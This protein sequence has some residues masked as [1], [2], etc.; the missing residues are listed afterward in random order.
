M[1][2]HRNKWTISSIKKANSVG[3]LD[4]LFNIYSF[5][6]APPP[7]ILTKEVWDH[8]RDSYIKKDKASLIKHLL[9]L[10]RFPIDNPYIGFLRMNK[11]A[12]KNNSTIVDKIASLIKN[13]GINE[14]KHR[15]EASKASSRQMGQKFR[16]WLK[17]GS[18][19]INVIQADSNSFDSNKDF[20]QFDG[21]A[22][23]V[24]SDKKLKEIA[25]ECLGYVGKKGID[26][27]AKINNHFII[28]EAKFITNY[29]GSQNEQFN[30]A[31]S[32]LIM[33][34]EETKPK[35]NI[36]KVA[37]LDGVIYLKNEKFDKYFKEH[38]EQKIMSCL[39]LKDFLESLRKKS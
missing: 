38:G 8:I 24:A 28:G 37:I 22:V 39:V 20:K 2:K 19:G 5:E 6:V 30:D 18:L 7:R 12:I 26:F 31:I 27:L 21:D 11:N 25:S 23:F 34:F 3:Y 36:V 14:L 1:G 15:C 10:E 33:Q 32:L 4:E 29:G 17:S 16:E 9:E 13:L 35:T